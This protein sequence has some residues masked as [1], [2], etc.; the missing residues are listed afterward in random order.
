MYMYIYKYISVNQTTVKSTLP[1]IN[2]ILYHCMYKSLRIN[3]QN[4]RNLSSTL[5]IILSA[6]GNTWH[7]IF[8]ETSQR[9]LSEHTC[10]RA[11]TEPSTCSGTVITSG[12]QTGPEYQ[13]LTAC[14]IN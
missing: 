13:A 2:F 8:M 3:A 7:H 6:S 5:Y 14:C 11:H 1:C 4:R 9:M 10:H 12:L